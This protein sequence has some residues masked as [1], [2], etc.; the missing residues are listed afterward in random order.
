M[1]HGA[2]GDRAID[3]LWSRGFYYVT[4]WIEGEGSAILFVV[5]PGGFL[6]SGR[7]GT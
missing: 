1:S 4:V 3:N 2:L 7:S 6:R 5:D